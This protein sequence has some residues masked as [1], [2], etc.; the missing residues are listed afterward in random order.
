MT[1]KI[2]ENFDYGNIN[3]ENKKT[4]SE[5]INLIN[6]LPEDTNIKMLATLLENKFKL[7]EIPRYDAMQTEIVNKA[8]KIGLIPT[9]AGW[10]QSVTTTGND[11]LYPIIYFSADIRKFI[12]LSLELK[13]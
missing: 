7:V 3:D 2:V 5:I 11:M 1:N 12:E 9:I 10:N 8:I 6:Q 13:K 4:V